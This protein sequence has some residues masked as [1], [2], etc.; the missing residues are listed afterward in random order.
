MNVSQ[1]VR[2]FWDMEHPKPRQDRKI[3]QAPKLHLD[4]I[5]GVGDPE[6]KIRNTRSSWPP[7][8][9]RCYT[10]RSRLSTGLMRRLTLS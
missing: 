7:E 4:I 5:S 10:R 9:P 1:G 3:L 8:R 6:I 2:H